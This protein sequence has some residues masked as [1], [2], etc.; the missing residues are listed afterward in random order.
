MT[1]RYYE[2][3]EIGDSASSPSG[4]TI[5]ESEVYTIAGLEGNYSPLHTNEEYAKTEFGGRIAQNTFLIVLSNGLNNQLPWDPATI[6]AYGRENIR[7]VTPV[8]IGDTVS[9]ES[10]VV[11][12]RERDEDS[13]IVTFREDLYNQDGDLA[14]TG[15]YLMLLERAP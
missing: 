5:S 1:K 13:G 2:D 3:F 14:V 4:R 9:L 7:F 8:L 10:E 11:A 12:K 6:A 15:E